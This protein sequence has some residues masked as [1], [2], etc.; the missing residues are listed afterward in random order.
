MGSGTTLKGKIWRAVVFEEGEEVGFKNGQEVLAVHD[1]L[2]K[3]FGLGNRANGGNLAKI[4]SHR[5]LTTG[6]TVGREGILVGVSSGVIGL[7]GINQ[8]AGNGEND[9]EF[10]VRKEIMQVLKSVRFG[11]GGSS[12]V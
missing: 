6:G 2:L 8:H 3:T 5:G 12:P 1:A 9:E 7:A 10:K 4:E 11:A